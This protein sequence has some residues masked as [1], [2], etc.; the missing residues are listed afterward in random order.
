MYSLRMIGTALI[1]GFTGLPMILVYMFCNTNPMALLEPIGGQP[2]FQLF[3][4]AYRSLPLAVISGLVYLIILPISATM[5]VLT[6]S[7]VWWAFAQLGAFTHQEWNCRIGAKSKIPTNAAYAVAAVNALIGI[8]VFGPPEV[9]RNIL[10]TSVV[11][12]LFSYFLPIICFLFR[13]RSGLTEKRYFNLGRLGWLVNLVAAAWIL[14][15]DFF[16]IFPGEYPVTPENMNYSVVVIAGLFL[17][18]WINW[19]M[20]ARRNYTAPTATSGIMTMGVN[21]S[22]LTSGSK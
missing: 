6:T 15:A 9:L 1:C 8:L 21:L 20:H 7:R 22:D 5:L 13:G 18:G 4:D 3:V 17:F 2:I 12:G 14:F 16:I 19:V 10:G 11:C